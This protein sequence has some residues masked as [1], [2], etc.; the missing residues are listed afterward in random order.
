[1]GGTVMRH[2]PDSPSI[3]D[4]LEELAQSG[5]AIEPA[6]GSNDNLR[7]RPRSA[8]TPDLAKRIT[9]H[10]SALL[11]ALRENQ[12]SDTTPKQTEPISPDETESGDVSVLSVS[13]QGTPDSYALWSV[14]ELALLAREGKTP[15]D[16]PLVDEVKAVFADFGVRVD[17]MEPKRAWTRHQIAQLLWD[18]R[19]SDKVDNEDKASALR[20]AW[21]KRLAICT[22]DEGLTIEAAEEI[23]LE[24]S[25]IMLHH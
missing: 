3:I 18:A 1:M 5:I 19:Q 22:I 16:M 14:E 24:E 21:L 11:I 15:E 20:S 12:P 17:S 25:E 9:N 2:T 23:A 4:L 13:E 8:M 7:F 10:K 6:P